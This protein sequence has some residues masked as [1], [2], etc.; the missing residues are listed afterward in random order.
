[1]KKLTPFISNV[2]FLIL[3]FASSAISAQ[4]LGEIT[5]K[6]TD[7]TGEA[8]PG[9]T[10]LI[11]GTTIGTAT[12]FNGIFE[13]GDVPLG[14]QVLVI[15]FV[16]FQTTE[17]NVDVQAGILITVNH[18]LQTS[19][20]ELQEVVVIAEAD[21]RYSS[22]RS[23]TDR[24][25]INSIKL[26]EGVLV[27]VSNEQI[28]KSVDRDASQIVK[29]IAGVSLVDRFVVVRGM[30]P[31]YN[32][33]LVNGI[34]G[35]SSEE[36]SRAFSFDAI[37]AR[38]IDRLE[39][40]KSPGPHIPAMWGGGVIKV[41]TKSFTTSRQLNIGFS[42]AP[43]TGGSSFTNDFVT[44]DTRGNSDWL[45]NGAKDRRIPALIRQPYFNF[46][47]INQYPFENIA[48]S[49]SGIQT[50]TPKKSSHSFD[51]RANITYYDNFRIGNKTLN[52]LS[53]ISYTQERFI[54]RVDQAQNDGDYSLVTNPEQT[55]DSVLFT[56][57][58]TNSS[59]QQFYKFRPTDIFTDSI[60]EEQIRIAAVQSFGIEFNDDH[61][62]KTTLF[63]NRFGTDRVTVRNG[64]EFQDGNLR[65]YKDYIYSYTQRDIFMAQLGGYHQMGKHSIDW[66]G[67]YA[68]T[69][70]EVPD[71]QRFRFVSDSR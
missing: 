8:V 55:M 24:Q 68:R 32:L 56:E 27:G 9:A 57:Q 16:G 17:I 43:R 14:P 48:L 25:L 64:T 62:L 60:H 61:N 71:F 26:N 1:M 49:R 45:A 42:I 31:R 30:D 28:L 65:N 6:I 46:P 34:I 15:S 37:P 7:D 47:D 13:L 50:F 4:N 33:T 11:K 70:N 21:V 2:L 20:Q 40:D 41:F 59:G 44:Y 63:Y 38:I 67:G 22:L 51:K 23:S 18:T 52:S 12:N 53:A 29:R 54:W 5:G 19:V 10:V 39:V 35:P 58:V 66:V 69:K 36:E 3:L